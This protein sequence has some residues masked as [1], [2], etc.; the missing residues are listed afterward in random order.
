VW[1][2]YIS[3]GLLASMFIIITACNTHPDT[4]D[5]AT[6]KS[7]P[8]Q[9]YYENENISFYY[10][11]LIAENISSETIDA[12][13]EGA[14]IEYPAYI[15]KSLEDYIIYETSLSPG[16][17]IFPLEEYYLLSDDAAATIDRLKA[18]IAGKE[19]AD[20]LIELPYLPEPLAAQQFFANPKLLESSTGTGLRFLT[21]YSQD[22]AP[23]TNQD[24]FYTYQGLTA[25]QAYYISAIFPVN[26]PELP[27]DWDDYFAS[28]GTDYAIFEENYTDNLEL[29][30]MML[31]EASVD[32]FKPSLQLLDNIIKSL[33]IEK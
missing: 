12:S 11:P 15:L 13:K 30:V 1:Y 25:D 8:E 7:S 28:S 18:I 2:K 21:Q 10:P 16:M 29:T 27:L 9:I 3:T 4:E 22:L 33:Q 26:H 20:N 5:V 19:T 31:D 24:L 17:Q 6:H 23:V 32:D 14:F